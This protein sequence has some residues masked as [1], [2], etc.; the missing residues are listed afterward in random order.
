MHYNDFLAVLFLESFY[1]DR[2]ILSHLR[3]SL[4]RM[5]LVQLKQRPATLQHK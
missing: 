4:A 5:V 1:T 3:S 2:K